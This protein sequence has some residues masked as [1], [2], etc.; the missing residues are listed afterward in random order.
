MKLKLRNQKD[1]TV[2][3][4]GKKRIEHMEINDLIA[5]SIIDK[6]PKDH[7][8]LGENFARTLCVIEYPTRKAGAW[9]SKLY[10][11]KGNVTTVTHYK[12]YPADKMI[13][14]LSDSVEEYESQ[15]D[16]ALKP[17]RRIEVKKRLD[18]A[19]S[20]LSKLLE[21]DNALILHVHTYVHIVAE[22]H[23]ELERI[24]KKVNKT[25]NKLGLKSHIPHDNILQA[26]EAVLPI[27]KNTL[28]EYTYRNM[29]ADAASSLF[30]FDESELFHQSKDAIMKGRNKKTDSI[31]MVDQKGLPSHNEYVVGQTGMGKSFYIKKDMLRHYM[32]GD[33]IFI[34]DPENEFSSIVNKIGGVVL[35]ISASSGHIINPLEI[36]P[37][38]D[39]ADINSEA[40]DDEEEEVIELLSQKIQRLKIWFKTIKKDLTVL[41]G[42]I[43][44]NALFKMYESF[45][46]RVGTDFTQ[47][48]PTDYPILSDLLKVL[49][50]EDHPKLADFIE[51]LRTYV[52][53][54]N[55]RMFN[56]HTNVDLKNR[57]VSFNL[58]YLEDEGDSQPAAMYNILS[59]LWDEIT[60]GHD[61]FIKLYVD[62]AHKMA[63]P[64][65]PRAMKFLYQIYKRIRKYFGGCTVATQAIADFLSAI[66]GARNYG[67]AII[68]SS[69]SKMIL[70]LEDGDIDDLKRFKVIKLS[71]EEE[72]IL[73]KM[74]QGEG[75]Y[76]VGRIRVHIEVDHSPLEMKLIDPKKYK[77]IYEK[78]LG[79][80]A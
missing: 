29:D 59:Y 19:E 55:A 7:I 53:G 36:R 11:Y 10:R 48:K 32:K 62:E 28:P 51:I 17:R 58:K 13:K 2:T 61:R 3:E 68:G 46:M 20:M 78:D 12:P 56:G 69:L 16:Q 44:E 5:P 15:L 70:G 73:R 33:K 67:K 76:V 8:Q 14:H 37:R 60:E 26:F 43:L 71:A 21:E 27:N 4:W 64:D 66:E 25:L 63:D 47:F 74:E 22:S 39:R 50:A 57:V 42:A 75:I 54:T 77:K 30:P 24:T 52:T 38:A 31:I 41:E 45:D 72:R 9:A 1:E 34:I 80:G 6:R 23:E 40:K 79:K 65:N 49:E 18:S 35:H